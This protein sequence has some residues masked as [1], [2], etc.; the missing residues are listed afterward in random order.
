ME[1]NPYP[2]LDFLLPEMEDAHEDEDESAHDDEGS[3][4]DDEE[5]ANSITAKKCV[6]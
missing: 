4:D 6:K 2:F 3:P 5:Q 1:R